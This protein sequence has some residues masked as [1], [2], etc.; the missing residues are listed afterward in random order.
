MTGE[1]VR[2]LAVLPSGAVIALLAWA[3]VVRF[4]AAY[5]RSTV[6]HDLL[7]VISLGNAFAATWRLWHSGGV[8][9]GVIWLACALVCYGLVYHQSRLQVAVQ[10]EHYC[11]QQITLILR[12]QGRKKGVEC[13]EGDS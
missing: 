2:E 5:G 10:P 6:Q 3:V 13:H 8:A 9:A 4:S 12:P 7:V 11:E 1:A